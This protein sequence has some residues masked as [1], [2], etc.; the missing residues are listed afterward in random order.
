MTDSII[1]Y[2]LQAVL[3]VVAILAL[4][5]DWTEYKKRTDTSGKGIRICIFAATIVL[6]LLNLLNTHFGR[7]RA[8]IDRTAAEK[9]HSDERTADKL[10]IAGLNQSIETQTRNNETQYTRHQDELHRLQDQ[11]TDLKKQVATEELRKKMDALQGRLDRALTPAP[12]AKLQASFWQTALQD[13]IVTEIYAPVETNVVTFSITLVNHSDVD[14]IGDVSLWIRVCEKCKFN[15]EPQGFQHI[16]GA[17]DTERLMRFGDLP[18]GSRTQKIVV[19]AEVPPDSRGKMVLGTRYRCNNCEIEK[20]WQQMWVTLGR[21]PFPNSLLP[22]QKNV[23][24]R[25]PS[26]PKARRFP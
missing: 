10:Q 18:A 26:V 23:K 17:P 25:K 9:R 11:L 12:K 20:D 19:D 13:D 3:G 1:S 16:D 15:K 2:G 8:A 22:P 14:A 21:V 6:I 5:K 4:L 24:S 7:V